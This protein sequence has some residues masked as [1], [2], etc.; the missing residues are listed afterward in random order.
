MTGTHPE[1][2]P[3]KQ[4]WGISATAIVAGA[5]ASLSAA[6]VAS[7]FGVAGTL[8]GTAVVSIISSVAAAL[9]TGLLGKTQGLVQRTTTVLRVS[10]PTS[11]DHKA[12]PPGP[13]VGPEAAPGTAG[14]SDGHAGRPVPPGSPVRRWAVIGGAAVLIFAI[15]IGVVTG[16][17][18]AIKEP[19]ATA[20]GVRHRGEASTSVGV[21]VNRAGGGSGTTQSS[22][23]SPSSTQ[24][25][26][27][28]SSGGQPGQAPP[29]TQPGPSTTGGQAP[30]STA[31]STT[32][33]PT[34]PSTSGGGSGSR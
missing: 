16:I 1:E 11:E 25:R 3:P 32:A 6:V 14:P 27:P 30:P 8:I 15:T 17:E 33:A 29:T 21:A 18:A 20:L 2:Q 10:P 5:L 31:P 12:P 24:P 23:P 7:F 4:P 13:A 9:Y 19:I 34:A 22:V 26:V 28:P